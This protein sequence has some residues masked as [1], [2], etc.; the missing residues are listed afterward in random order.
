MKLFSCKPTRRKSTSKIYPVWVPEKPRKLSKYEKKRHAAATKIQAVARG[1][2]ARKE[3]PICLQVL[4]S[5][6]AITTLCNHKFHRECI[7]K[8]VET[9]RK[10]SCPVCRGD[11]NT[12]PQPERVYVSPITF[13][14]YAD[15]PNTLVGYSNHNRY[16]LS[17][18]YVY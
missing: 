11:L 9:K 13:Y 10:C 6:K 3:C 16:R 5:K 15:L 8:W 4:S 14:Q 7:E 18:N 1:K 17:R 2:L 12:K